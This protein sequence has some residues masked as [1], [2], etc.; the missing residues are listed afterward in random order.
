MPADES[1]TMA[2]K[3]EYEEISETETEELTEEEISP[4]E[5][6]TPEQPPTTTETI[7]EYEEETT[8][9]KEIISAVTAITTAFA[10]TT[11]AITTAVSE[12]EPTVEKIVEETEYPTDESQTK[13]EETDETSQN[14]VEITFPVGIALCIVTPTGDNPRRPNVPYTGDAHVTFS[15]TDEKGEIIKEMGEWNLSDIGRNVVKVKFE[16]TVYSEE[17]T[18]YFMWTIDNIDEGYYPMWGWEETPGV[19]HSTV[20]IDPERR[21]RLILNAESNAEAAARG[22]PDDGVSPIECVISLLPNNAVRDEST[23]DGTYLIYGDANLDKNVTISDSVAILQ[24]IANSEKYPLD[25]NARAN[26]D[27]YNPGDGITGSDANSIMKLDA[28]IID[29]LPEV[30]S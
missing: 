16:Q 14:G 20:T 10:G 21:E 5:G 4:E 17:E 29:S 9:K 30:I 13:C 3:S 18:V 23:T 26:A 8:M 15:Q 19:I 7:T 1:H 2:F 6:D 27:V 12:T 24:N 25:D 11:A 22:V 28:G